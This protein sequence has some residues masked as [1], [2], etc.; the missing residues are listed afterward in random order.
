[1]WLSSFVL[2]PIAVYLIIKATNDSS[3]LDTEWYYAK[4]QQFKEQIAPYW[5]P[6]RNRITSSKMWL[7]MQE[8]VAKRK[9]NK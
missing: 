4:M 1:M 5:N 6:V 9:K 7:K 3:L 2:A 8:Q